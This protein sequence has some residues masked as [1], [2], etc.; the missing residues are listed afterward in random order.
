MKK[1]LFVLMAI[2]FSITSTASAMQYHVAGSEAKGGVVDL[3]LKR[4]DLFRKMR[5][6]VFLEEDCVSSCTYYSALLAEELV[7]ARPGVLLV[8]HKAMRY[9]PRKVDKQGNVTS[10]WIE[11]PSKKDVQKTWGVYPKRVKEA[12]LRRS[13]GGLPYP[14]EE[15]FIPATEVGIPYC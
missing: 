12:V 2:M 15:I 1:V 9:R 7:C 6:K 8:F 14:G 4:I 10:F 11:E 13:P 3:Y 5:I